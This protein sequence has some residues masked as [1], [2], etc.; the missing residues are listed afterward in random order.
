[1]DLKKYCVNKISHDT[2]NIF[3]KPARILISGYSGSGK[4]SLCIQLLKY[5]R[6]KFTN[7]IIVNSPNSDE[8]LS[9]NDLKDILLVYEFYPTI[10]EIETKFPG[11]VCII[12]DDNYSSS[13]NSKDV[14][15]YFTR[16]RHIKLSVILLTQNLFYTSG[17]FSRDI[18]LNVTHFILLRLRD[19]NQ[20]QII[21]TQIFGKNH[22]VLKIY[23]YIMNKYKYGHLLIDL[24]IDSDQKTQLRSNII[25][26]NKIHNF[27]ICY[28]II[29]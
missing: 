23:K 27:E 10:A 4:T 28:K 19:L 24:S 15:S 12:L 21:G 25:P 2:V 29:E 26:D 14:H 8:L 17:K 18:S 1:M 11:K 9:V 6:H 7:I 22:S 3:N 13:L 5:Y 16:G 20:I